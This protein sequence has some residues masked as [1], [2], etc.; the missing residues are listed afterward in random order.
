ML[1]L[2]WPEWAAEYGALVRCKS[3]EPSHFS[4]SIEGAK[5]G[6]GMGSEHLVNPLVSEESLRAKDLDRNI[7]LSLLSERDA[8][9]QGGQKSSHSTSP[10]TG[11][12]AGGARKQDPLPAWQKSTSDFPDL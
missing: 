1:N 12:S 3:A 9:G 6:S 7:L 2:N 10:Q 8:E 5:G 4:L 11:T